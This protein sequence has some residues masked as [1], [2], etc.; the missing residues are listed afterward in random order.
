MFIIVKAGGAQSTA[1]CLLYQRSLWS[2]SHTSST[3]PPPT[4]IPRLQ[5]PQSLPAPA[6]CAFSVA[7]PSCGMRRGREAP[8]ALNQADTPPSAFQIEASY[9]VWVCCVRNLAHQNTRY[10]TRQNSPKPP[11]A[12]DQTRISRLVISLAPPESTTPVVMFLKG[13]V[14]SL[15]ARGLEGQRERVGAWRG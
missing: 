7:A 8:A 10:G 14:R 3:C 9:R 13:K 11:S 1:R 4:A 6:L 15:S 5:C 12:H 2:S